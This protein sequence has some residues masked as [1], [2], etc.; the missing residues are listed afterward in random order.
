MNKVAIAL[1]TILPAVGT[2]GCAGPLLIADM[3]PIPVGGHSYGP[4]PWEI[5]EIEER[6][7]PRAE[8]IKAYGEPSAQTTD[9]RFVLYR[10]GGTTEVLT[11]GATH[12]RSYAGRLLLEFDS[13]D[14]VKRASDTQCRRG[15]P[16]PLCDS[17]ATLSLFAM[18][19]KQYGASVARKY[20]GPIAL[21]KA[22]NTG[23]RSIVQALLAEGVDVNSRCR[24]GGTPLHAA[25]PNPEPEV[26]K[27]LLEHGGDVN[28]KDPA[29]RTPLHVAVTEGS[30]AMVQLL[31][32]HGAQVNVV[33]N[34]GHTPLHLASAKGAH[35][36]VQLLLDRQAEVNAKD[37]SGRTPL[38]IAVTGG[39]LAVTK[40]LLAHRA[41][42]NVKDPNDLTP[43]HAAVIGGSADLVRLL[44]DHRAEVNAKDPLN[45]R[46][47]L[48]YAATTNAVTIASY[49][50]AAGAAANVVDDDGKR[51]ID[52]ATDPKVIEL[53]RQH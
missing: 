4:E 11:M 42:V 52:L 53:L 48:H 43:L 18:L 14:R 30:L 41:A 33:D 5:R 7:K 16:D 6:A 8:I 9:G 28:P 23:D 37:R 21:C 17:D 20:Q 2:G 25:V 49:L 26:A 38:Q 31:L 46:T 39:N 32:A 12:D 40:L 36:L 27:V 35:D 24:E 29:G 45:G 1:V 10:Y 34:A 47:P 19:E 13:N 3:I 22:A 44:L 50:L 15:K 51:P